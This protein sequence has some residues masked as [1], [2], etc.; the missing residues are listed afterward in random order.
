[1]HCLS[2]DEFFLAHVLG[3]RE[4]IP[5]AIMA[6]V[7]VLCRLCHPSSELHIAEHFFE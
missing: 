6:E 1:M 4:E 5:W 7:L 3:G 2:L